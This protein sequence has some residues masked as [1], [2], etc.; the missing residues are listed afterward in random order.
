MEINEIERDSR[1]EVKES[2]V[3]MSRESMNQKPD[4]TSNNLNGAKR[5]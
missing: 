1:E 2:N 3:L 4:T 5:K